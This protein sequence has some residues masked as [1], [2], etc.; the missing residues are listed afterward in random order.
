VRLILEITRTC[1]GRYEGCLT[2]PETGDQHDFA[3]LLEL[4]AILED[5]LESGPCPGP[6]PARPGPGGTA[7]P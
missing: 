1:H 4:V 3:G 5:Q 7:P 6:P 2:L